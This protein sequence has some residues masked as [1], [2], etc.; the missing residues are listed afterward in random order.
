MSWRLTQEQVTQRERVRQAQALGQREQA[1]GQREQ[2]PESRRGPT[3]PG[4]LQGPVRQRESAREQARE[5]VQQRVAAKE[6]VA[7]QEPV[8]QPAPVRVLAGVWVRRPE[9]EWVRE[10]CRRAEHRRRQ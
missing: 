1:L 5:R 3:R 9:Q 8:R 7:E 6:R 4:R 10:P 2:V